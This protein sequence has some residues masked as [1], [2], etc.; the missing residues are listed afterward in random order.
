MIDFLLHIDKH[1]GEL[2]RQHG[3]LTYAILAAIVFAETGFVVTPFLP[4]DSLLFAVG[5]FC[6][7][8]KDYHLNFGI[9]FAVFMFAA[10]GGDN[11][12]YWLGRTVG[13]RLF[14]NEK[15]RFLKRSN[16]DK[17]HA[18]FEKHGKKTIVLARFVP[19]V[20]TFCPF[21]A[22]MG[23]MPYKEFL[24]WSVIGAF[25]WV[26]IFL[27]AGYAVATIPAVQK[28]FSLA[29]VAMVVVTGA[30]LLWEVWRSHK[31]GEI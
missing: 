24:L 15:S 2:I 28:N 8:S 4:G 29:V 25:L 19:I 3:T 13:D 17:T 7:P 30:P 12:N 14:K 18:F 5:I 6:H 10:L 22:G 20:R 9:M 11:V 16:L 31:R 21:V 27:T 1:I 23:K 26:G